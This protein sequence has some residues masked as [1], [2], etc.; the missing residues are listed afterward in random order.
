M[1]LTPYTLKYLETIASRRDREDA[2]ERKSSGFGYFL[3][4]PLFWMFLP[5]IVIYELFR[6]RHD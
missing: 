4:I 2:I 5:Y 6:M 1:S 3:L